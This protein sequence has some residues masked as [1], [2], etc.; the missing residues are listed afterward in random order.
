M[1]LSN[2]NLMHNKSSTYINRPP[3]PAVY[4]VKYFKQHDF[5]KIFGARKLLEWD[6][7]IYRD[8]K[9]NIDMFSEL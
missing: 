4:R 5:R 2:I 8:F 1:A 3:C 7:L 6:L 9:D